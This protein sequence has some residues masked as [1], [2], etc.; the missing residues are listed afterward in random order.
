M[1]LVDAN[2]LLAAVNEADPRH[3]RARGWLDAELS[4]GMSVGFAWIVLLAFL[5][6]ST[7]V[8]LFPRPLGVD[9]ALD[10]VR[11]WLAAPDAVVVQETAT[12]LEVLGSLL[13]SLGTGANLTS[14]AHLAALALE[15][16]VGVVTFD[17]DFGRF[18]GVRWSQPAA[19]R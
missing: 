15:H 8:G 2:V 18:P 4:G 16:R 19:E 13:A 6:L 7:K 1:N 10:V 14:D 9:D 3:E 11:A 12:H 17:S 5:R